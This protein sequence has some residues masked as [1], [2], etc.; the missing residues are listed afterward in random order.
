MIEGRITGDGGALRIEHWLDAERDQLANWIP[1]GLGIGIAAWQFL[2]DRGIWPVIAVISLLYGAS[3]A[4]AKGRWSR[5]VL[6]GAA[7]A[8]GVGFAVIAAKSALVAEPPLQKIWIGSFY[9]RIAKVESLPARD[10]VRLELETGHHAGLPPKVRVNLSPGQY[11]P[12]FLPGAVILLRARLMPP[13]PPALPGGYDFARRA[14]FARIGAT[15]TA[16]GPVQLYKAAPGSAWLPA[17]RARLGAHVHRNMP[18][19]DGA[20][21]A[22]FVNGDQGGIGEHDADAMR[23]SGLAHLLSISGLHVTAAVGAIFFLTSRLL[24][25]FP[26]LALRVTVPLVAAGAGAL[27]AIGY[28]LLTGSEVPTVRSCVAA[29]LVLAALALGREAL[30]TRVVAFGAAFVLLFWPDA[31]AGPSFQLSFAAVATIIVLHET[32]WMNRHFGRRDEFIAFRLLRGLLSILLTGLAIELVL[33]PIAL[34][35]FHKTGLYGALA[36]V[37]AIPLTTF[38]IMPAEAL[39]LLF[40]IVGLGA[41]FWWVASEGIGII[42]QIAH[43]ISGLPGAVSMLPVMP[44]WAYGAILSGALVFG[45][46]RSNWRYAGM[47]PYA[48]GI[49]AMLLAPR[50]DILITGDGKHLALVSPRGSV[51]LLRTGAGD[52]VRDM[53]RENAGV[54]AEP[55]A[56]EAWPGARCSKDSCLIAVERGG[57]KWQILATRS[58]YQIDYNELIDI[59]SAS[60]IVVSDRWL[61]DACKPRWLKADRHFLARSG[62]LAIYLPSERIESVNAKNRH[63]PWARSGFE[64]RNAETSVITAQ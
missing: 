43:G 32:P 59:C 41:P 50:P 6:R 1:V 2:G 47:L 29:L 4:L 3:F 25:L 63:M 64:R 31:M 52:Y 60:D 28:T 45:L 46:L 37:V 57:R 10:T 42:L 24:S 49:G 8:I 55:M 40:D 48:I 44:I 62:G 21:G 15:G 26:W 33:A 12:D 35:H 56:I 7:L 61:P 17:L 51:A 30:T 36:N 11:R 22:A 5:A 23:N 14:W 54:V 20:I 19:P 18:G 34:F 39:A 58:R 27:G 13:A 38:V 16:L 9:A 53:I